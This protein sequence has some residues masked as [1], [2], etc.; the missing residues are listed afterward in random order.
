MKKSLK[1]SLFL[2]C[3]SLCMVMG[4]KSLIANQAGVPKEANVFVGDWLG[5]IQCSNPPGIMNDFNIVIWIENN[6]ILWTDWTAN[7]IYR[8]QFSNETSRY[9]L[10]LSG[11]SPDG[12]ERQYHWYIDKNVKGR[13]MYGEG[14][15]DAYPACKMFLYK[16]LTHWTDCKPHTRGP[17]NKPRIISNPSNF[18]DLSGVWYDYT[19]QHG[20]KGS[21]STIEQNGKNL[22]FINEFNDRSEGYFI[23]S[24]TIIATKWEGGLKASLQN[25]NQRIVFTNGSVWE[26]TKRIK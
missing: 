1:V 3:L 20:N 25:G 10:L 21:V 4:N 23:N 12:K 24:Q 9:K 14:Y 13:L 16:G 11:K 6:Q 18:P 7:E 26:R 22:I 8:G 2:L 5:A 19:A 17:V 15:H